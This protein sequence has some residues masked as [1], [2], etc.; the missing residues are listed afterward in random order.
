MFSSKIGNPNFSGKFVMH[1]KKIFVVD[2]QS[3]YIEY[4][5]TALN[6]RIELKSATGLKHS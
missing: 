2:S 1:N 4:Y 5:D 3:N 6:K